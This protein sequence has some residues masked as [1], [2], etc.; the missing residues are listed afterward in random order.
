[1]NLKS[2]VAKYSKLLLGEFNAF[3]QKYLTKKT[4]ESKAIIT[5]LLLFSYLDY[6]TDKTTIW[7]SRLMKFNEEVST[8]ETSRQMTR[9]FN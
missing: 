1:M 9:F 4:T 2:V 8:L 6:L 5:Q 7:L 3:M